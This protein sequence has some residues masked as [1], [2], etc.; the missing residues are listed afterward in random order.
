[1]RA[2]LAGWVLT[3]PL[4]MAGPVSAGA[5]VQPRDG[6]QVIV[7]FEDMRASQGYDLDGRL[8]DLP[9]PRRDSAL[10]V[11]A[12][13]GL[14]DRLTLQL[15]AD[16]QD[17]RD[18]F[19]DY[20]GRGPVE[21]GATWQVWRDDAAAFSLYGGYADAGDARN[22]GHAN[23]GEGQRDWELRASV[24]RSVDTAGPRW[25]PDRAFVEVQAARRVRDGLPDETR[26]DL[27]LGA[28]FGRRW[29]A[30]AQA[31]GGRA[32]HGARWVSV[33]G[34]IVR[35]QGA[36]SLQAGWRRAVHGREAPMAQ[37]LVFALWRR[38]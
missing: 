1:M 17:G 29:L 21:I 25:A 23:P 7:K 10:G 37:G 3:V 5:W 36:W 33:E 12:E 20:R 11:F 4:A 2:G 34:S 24:G 14:T 19:F 8:R 28:H 27:T 18:A 26:M 9:A 35:A 38:F 6:G 22:A 15:K 30:L 31:Y 32:D 13:Y 16:A